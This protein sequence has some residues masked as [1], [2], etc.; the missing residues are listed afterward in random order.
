MLLAVAIA[1]VTS[2]CGGSTQGAAGD[3]G[4]PG[5]LPES[6][7]TIPQQGPDLGDTEPTPG[8][9]ESE[10]SGENDLVDP[11]TSPGIGDTGEWFTD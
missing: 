5:D 3:S 10:A 1:L 9:D 7:G 4:S 8:Q 2:A 11:T 6:T